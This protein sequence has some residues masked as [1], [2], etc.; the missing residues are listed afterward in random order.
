MSS[1]GLRALSGLSIGVLGE[2]IDIHHSLALS[3]GLL[4]LIYFALLVYRRVRGD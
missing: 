1:L 2:S 4:F 3:A